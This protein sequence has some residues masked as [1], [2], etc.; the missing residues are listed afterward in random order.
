MALSRIG[1]ERLGVMG[2]P[3]ANS[4][5]TQ[6]PSVPPVQAPSSPPWSSTE[7]NKPLDGR[8]SHD[9]HFLASSDVQRI[10]R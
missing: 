1:P 2:F 3:G 10:N 5:N 7:H 9:E 4:R 6:P 8:W